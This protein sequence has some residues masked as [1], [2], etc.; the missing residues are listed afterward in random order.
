[1]NLSNDDG[2]K[3]RKMCDP[4][5]GGIGNKLNTPKTRLIQT[6]IEK[7]TIKAGFDNSKNRNKSPTIKALKK[8]EPG[9]ASPTNAG[10]H[11]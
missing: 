7:N 8:F 4:S 1:L 2:K 10:P 11:F 6:K 3:V 9:P 5:R